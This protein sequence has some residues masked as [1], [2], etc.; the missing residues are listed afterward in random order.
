MAANKCCEEIVTNCK[1]LHTRAGQ[2][3]VQNANLT[4]HN[5]AAPE[6]NPSESRLARETCT[7]LSTVTNQQIQL[8]PHIC[9]QSQQ[10]EMPFFITSGPLCDH[11]TSRLFNRS[12]MSTRSSEIFGLFQLRWLI[13]F[14][15]NVNPTCRKPRSELVCRSDARISTSLNDSNNNK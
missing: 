11:N 1:I 13:T 2:K 15:K 5:A 14:S 4:T 12:E 10:Q 8:S 3:I 6:I 7:T 9:T